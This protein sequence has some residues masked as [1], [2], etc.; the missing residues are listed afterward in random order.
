ML[1]VVWFRHPLGDAVYGV[2]VILAVVHIKFLIIHY[3]PSCKNTIHYCCLIPLFYLFGQVGV[4]GQVF[5]Q[6]GGE[7]V[8]GNFN[9]SKNDIRDLAIWRVINKLAQRVRVH[10]KGLNFYIILGNRVKVA[11]FSEFQHLPTW[12]MQVLRNPLIRF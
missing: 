10:H 1:F 9:F 7:E 8:K 12:K 4:V 3:G 2:Y 5:L 6:V 11:E